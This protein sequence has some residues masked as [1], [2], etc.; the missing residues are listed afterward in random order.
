M[1]LS[2]GSPKRLLLLASLNGC[3]PGAHHHI[4][5]A[6]QYIQTAIHLEPLP[7]SPV[8]PLVGRFPVIPFLTYAPIHHTESSLNQSTRQG[9][10][11]S[12]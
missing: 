11:P 10:A 12:P 4:L 6:H 2:K 8:V 3:P 5:L 9:T 1:P 7:L